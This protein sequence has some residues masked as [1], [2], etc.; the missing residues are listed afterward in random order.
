MGIPAPSPLSSG[1]AEPVPVAFIG[2]TSTLTMQ[3]P[4]NSLRRQV[5]ECQAKLPPGWFIAAHYWDIES[6]GLPLDQRGHGTAHEQFTDIGIPR[7]GGMADLLTDASG[8]EPRFAA[9]MCE[10]IERSGRDTYYAL[11]LEKQLTNAGIPL[12]ATDEPIDIAGANATTVLVRRIKQGVADWFKLQVKEACWRG[13]REY[14]MAGYNIGAPPYGYVAVGIPHQNPLKASMGKTKMKLALD[15]DKA[16]AV[17]AI[18]TWRVDDKLGAYTIATRLAADPGRYPPPPGGWAESA[19][20]AIL[21]NP[22]YTGHQV[23]GRTRTIP[24][25]TPSGKKRVPVPETD[26]L[27]SLE[28]THPAIITRALWNASR[29]A[30]TE[31]S[32]SRDG[33]DLNTNPLTRRNYILRSRVRCRS[34]KRRMSGKTSSSPRYWADGPDYQNTYYT[35]CHNPD[36]PHATVPDGHPRTISVRE[37]DLL[38][39]IRKFFATH[40]FGPDRADLLAARMPATAAQDQER[41]DRQVAALNLRLRQIRT[42]ENAHA[43]EFEALGDLDDDAPAVLA[44]RS[45]I[46]DRFRELVTERD[47]IRKQLAHLRKTQPQR[48]D[49]ALLDEL[50]MLGD[51]LG[52]DAPLRFHQDLYQ[53]FDLQ[54]VYNKNDHQVSITVTI[55]D[56][57]PR[58]VAAI[59][60]AA[61][62]TPATTPETP[63]QTRFS[64]LSHTAISV[65]LA[66]GS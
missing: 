37:D 1:P 15:H 31:H 23:F 58:A 19:V 22:K 3:D 5:R 25:N 2:R 39:E 33:H 59:I 6:G 57:T 24:A 38:T 66:A 8:P 12:F 54:A 43:R 44:L 50:P 49:P 30:G 35:C 11:Q 47:Q 4:V 48:Q 63:A 13:L 55:T 20:Y 53:A 52:D 29:L 61:G 64:D 16:R 18:F 28:E 40:I 56:S 34:C 41:R 45:R 46:L 26:W 65:S 9:V 14:S 21:R 42:A 27:W 62:G 10:N 36:M 60:A 7:D 32:T 17:A 51:I